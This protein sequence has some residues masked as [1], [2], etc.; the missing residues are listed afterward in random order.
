MAEIAEGVLYQSMRSA[1]L[2][3]ALDAMAAER[4]TVPPRVVTPAQLL[5]E[6]DKE[7]E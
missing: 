3:K 1:L 2:Q 7:R 4:G 5:E 6:L